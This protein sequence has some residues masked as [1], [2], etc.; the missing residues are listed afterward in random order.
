[1]SLVGPRPER[2]FFV[3]QFEAVVPG[4]SERFATLP[5]ITGLGQIRSGYD[6]SLRTVQRK[7]RYDRLYVRRACTSL[8]FKLLLATMV[9]CAEDWVRICARKTVPGQ[10]TTVR[11]APSVQDR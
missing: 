8:D 2:A 10:A 7:I 4:Y 3:E 9:W 11:L 6:A 1:M 5:G